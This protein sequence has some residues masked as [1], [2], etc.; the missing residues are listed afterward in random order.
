[1]AEEII[2]FGDNITTPLS[3]DNGP[4][5]VTIGSGDTNVTIGDGND[6]IT[7]KNNDTIKVGNGSDIITIGNNDSLTVGSGPDTITAG[8]NDK[9]V[10]GNGG[11]T[12]TAG[13][14][15]NI[16]AG[17]GPD[18]ITAGPNSTII[19]GNGNDVVHV[20]HDSSV[21]LGSGPDTVHAGTTDTLSFNPKSGLDTID[22]DGLT[23]AFTVPAG[24]VNVNEEQS[25]AIPIT[26]LPPSLGNEVIN[27]FKT[28]NGIIAFDMND[29]AN[30]SQV[31]A[32]AAQSG[33]NVLITQPGGGGT[34]TITNTSL[35]SLSATNFAFFTGAV[36]Q[37]TISGVPTDATLSAGTQTSPGTWSLTPSQ[38]GGLTLNAGEPTP[39]DTLTVTM[40]NPAGQGATSSQSFPLQV[41]AIPPTVGVSVLPYQTGDS[42]D[43]TRLQLS[44]AVDSGDG[45]NDYINNI[46]L[47][48]VPTGV[49]LSS[50]GNTV[51]PLG[52]GDY[53][54][55]TTG[56]PASFNPEVDV[57]TPTFTGPT[58][59]GTDFNLGITANSSE[60]NGLPVD[61]TASTSQNIDVQYEPA[62][63]APTFTAS[64]QSIW[65]SGG[66]FS[67]TFSTFLGIQYPNGYP[68]HSG[69]KTAST[70]FT[71]IS[72]GGSFGLK[73]GFQ[74]NLTLNSGAFN[75][76]LPFSILVGNTFNKTND[77][78][79]LDPSDSQG[80]AS[81][82]TT[83]PQGS[84]SLDL[85]F[86]AFLRAFAGP[87][88]TSIGGS[89]NVPVVQLNSSTLHHTFNLPDG[90]GSVKVAWPTVDT[91]TSGSGSTISANGTSNP[92]FSVNIDPIAVV[93]DALIGSDPFKGTLASIDLLF[94]SAKI[95]YTLAAGTVEPTLNLKQVFS[96]NDAGLAP[97]LTDNGNP[98]SSFNFG[99]PTVIQNAPSSNSFSLGLTP[100][101]T[102]SNETSLLA[103]LILGLT[104]LKASATATVIGFSTSTSIGPLFHPHTTLNLGSVP[105]YKNTFPVNFGSQTVGYTVT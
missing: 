7:A 97:T 60:P 67:K 30:A 55:S 96:L 70:S 79:E 58:P 16:T 31:F 37:I 9:I 8:N 22:Y 5:I 54:I 103:Q 101:T 59:N 50:P 28:A 45:G 85:I 34:V 41:H 105:V 26:I 57:T 24:T 38:L 2:T 20:G 36:D 98:V 93:A 63:F 51:T 53:S 39:V 52:G 25:V 29:F 68:S 13:T 99:A 21:T 61:E 90:I 76:S 43:M 18:H 95:T 46:Q 62:S 81:F 44:S 78:L 47:S 4:S 91:S 32:N 77:T 56:H 12:I 49:T 35:S 104:L 11:D 94:G 84:Y 40:T 100:D 89:T 74:S 15:S 69:P 87:F 92:I 10:V 82:N 73:A 1:M 71:G 19:A 17:N 83:S 64:N 6:T 88:S 33:A 23:P 80:T 3:V 65:Q 72:I 48:N 66:N 27:G 42:I 75:G 102:L 86:D 14:N